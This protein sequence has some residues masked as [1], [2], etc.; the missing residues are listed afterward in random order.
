MDTKTRQDKLKK[1]FLTNK[2]T[3]SFILKQISLFINKEP[4]FMERTE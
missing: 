4:A 1:K 2:D 3:F